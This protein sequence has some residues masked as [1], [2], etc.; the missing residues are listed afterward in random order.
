M[1]SKEECQYPSVHAHMNRK[2]GLLPISLILRWPECVYFLV[3]PSS[4]GARVSDLR[5]LGIR[6]TPSVRLPSEGRYQC[7]LSFHDK[8]T[9][10]LNHSQRLNA[11]ITELHVRY[12]SR[13]NLQL[14]YTFV[15]LSITVFVT[16]LTDLILSSMSSSEASTRVAW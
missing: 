4:Q 9:T 6:L 13:H 2:Y 10:E 16:A 12:S 1:A 5:T 11:E 7:F 8:E 14:L 15:N 3:S